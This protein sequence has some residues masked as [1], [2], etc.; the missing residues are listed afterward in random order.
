MTTLLLLVCVCSVAAGVKV[1]EAMRPCSEPE[2][3][4]GTV[5]IQLSEGR[6]VAVDDG[7]RKQ[8]LLCISGKW[9]VAKL[10]QPYLPAYE[11]RN[12]KPARE[13][14]PKSPSVKSDRRKRSPNTG[15][16]SDIRRGVNVQRKIQKGLLETT[17][18]E[19]T[20]S[21]VRVSPGATAYLLCRVQ[22]LGTHS[23]T[24]TR[25]KDNH[26]LA[27]DTHQISSDRRLS[28]SYEEQTGTWILR[29]SRVRS[30][31]TGQY[32]CQVS[33]RPLLKKVVTLQVVPAGQAL[34]PPVAEGTL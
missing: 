29:I 24:W 28:P 21:T 9:S 23:V 18:E 7:I 26:V 8:L 15:K 32:E 31:D 6:V 10:D 2:V 3:S 1:E 30:Y 25:L 11:T 33:T 12:G 17:I 22:N 19:N 27:I 4:E 14:F 13:N 20:L 5:V 34:G 16:F